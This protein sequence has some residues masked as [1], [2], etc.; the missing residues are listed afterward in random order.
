[1]ERPKEWDDEADDKGGES[2]KY[3]LASLLNNVQEGVNH[4]CKKC[5]NI[6]DNESD[7]RNRS[8]DPE[9]FSHSEFLLVNYSLSRNP[10]GT[11]QIF[12]GEGQ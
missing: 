10:H 7:E 4:V 9:L 11:S 6:G 1:M 8:T 2:L 5:R 12:L 3:D